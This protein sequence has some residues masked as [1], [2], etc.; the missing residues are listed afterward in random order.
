MAGEE[1][2]L[3]SVTAALGQSV[4]AHAA[5]ADELVALRQALLQV[6]EQDLQLHR[7]T[8]KT[9]GSMRREIER[10]KRRLTKLAQART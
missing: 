9:V 3:R 1:N 4:E 8:L 7:R 2:E 10:L 5:E 6:S